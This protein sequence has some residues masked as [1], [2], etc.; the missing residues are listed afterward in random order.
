MQRV[1]L[2]LLLSVSAFSSSFAQEFSIRGQVVDSHSK[3]SLAATTVFAESIQ[4]SSLIAYTISD[5]DG[6]FELQ[7]KTGYKKINVFFL[8]NG[9]KP[10]ALKIDVQSRIDLKTV[11]L[12]EHAQELE[13][14][15][16]IGERAPI[17]IK[18]DTL[19]FNADSFRTRPDATVEDMLK[20]MPGVAID[21][22]GKITVNGK[23]V[24]RV[25]VDGQVFFNDD[26]KVATKNLPKEIIDKVQITDTKTKAQ[27]F[28]GEAGNGENKTIN[29]TVKENKNKGYLGRLAAGYGTDDT[30]QA[31]GLLNSFNDKERIS[32]IASSNNINNTSF[33]FDEIY[34]MVGSSR[35]GASFNRQ[36]GFSAGGLSSGFGQGITTSSTL[37]ASYANQD[38]GKYVVNG[39]YFFSYSDSFNDE[40]TARETILPDRR[41]FTDSESNFKGTTNSNQGSANLEFNMDKTLRISLQPSLGVN[42][43]NSFNVRNTVSTDE[44]GN[45]INGNKTETED[46]ALQRN[47][48]NELHI[49]K[50]LDPMGRFIRFSFNNTNSENKGISNLNSLQEVF[51]NDADEDILNQVSNVDNTND[52]Y[53]LGV[54]YRQPLA[55]K[56]FLDFGYVYRNTKQNNSK[57]VFDFNDTTGDFSIFNETLS[58]D[59]SFQNIQQQPSL[60]LMGNGEKLKF[61]ITAN[62]INTDL[63]N[64]DMLQNTSFS[65][66]YNKLLFAA[67]SS[68]TLGENKRISLRY[69]TNLGIPS[70]NQ[71]QPIPNVNNPLNIVIGNP[72]LAPSVSHKVDLNYDGYNWKNRTGIFMYASLDFRKD[73]V[74]AV[75]TTDENLLRTTTYTNLNGNYD[76]YGGIEYSKQ[77]RKDSTFT[78]KLNIRPSINV[79]RNIVFTNGVRLETKRT[80]INPAITTSFNFQDLIEIEPGYMISFNTTKYN[81][82]SFENIKFMAHNL[83]L[84]GITYWPKNLIWGNDIS[85]NYNGNVG[86]GFDKDAVFWNMSLGLQVMKKSGTVKLLAY[87]LLNQNI[88]TRRTTGQDFIQDF[89]GTVLQQYFMMSF[90]YKFDQFSGEKSGGRN[91]RHF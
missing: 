27:E 48:S 18:K 61:L 76:G 85:Y 56:L 39:N 64:Q 6:F 36:G 25:L 41:F 5:K 72:N 15:N 31:N 74:S 60:G 2:A 17:R 20:K 63:D 82:D 89:Q 54:A 30:Y 49:L 53:E 55:K 83:Q 79:S 62:Y 1:L 9:Y 77:I 86:P 46:D 34:D 42:Q 87:D 81:V 75:T 14:V 12:Q 44:D 7:G 47:F 73:D 24:D 78:A 10:L 65:K 11:Q 80:S 69:N 70:V 71:L 84:K 16:L 33:S 26:P 91:I 88:N 4:D 43:A 35:G 21:S 57:Q 13:G 59:F 45:L 8:F 32:F 50:K 68:Y 52:R 28:T 19:E 58:S 67:S 40:K 37:G 22:E 29:L 51:G 23:G 90:T 38:R 66:A 3:S